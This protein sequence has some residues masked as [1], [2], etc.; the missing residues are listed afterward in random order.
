VNRRNFIGATLAALGAALVP[1]RLG[2]AAPA[3]IEKLSGKPVQLTLVDEV[4]NAGWI[5]GFRVNAERFACR[6]R[7][8]EPGDSIEVS[9][10]KGEYKAPATVMIEM[11]YD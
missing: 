4:V 8:F 3:V 9:F 2:I 6:R 5:T 10:P 1:W 7:R 11:E